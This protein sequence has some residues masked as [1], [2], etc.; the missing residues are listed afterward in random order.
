MRVLFT[1]FAEDVGLIPNSAFTKLLSDLEDTPQKFAPMA[2]AV[3]QNM[4]KGGFSPV[5]RE[6]LLRFNGGLFADTQALPLTSNQ[7]GLL[8]EAAKSDWSD[9]EPA[10]F[11][12][13]LERALHPDERHKLGAHYTPRAYVERLVLPTVIEPLRE[14][15]EAAKNNAIKLAKKGGKNDLKK[16]VAIVGDFLKHL[17]TITV[18]DPACGSGNFL[19]VTLEHLKRLEGEV[20]DFLHSN[21]E[22]IQLPLEYTGLTVD[23]H[24]L[25]GIE[26]NP[27]AAAITDLVLW[28]GY[29]QWHFRTKGHT[30]PQEPVLKKF[31]NIECRDAVLAYDS[32]ELARD[33]QGKPL[34]RWDGKTYKKHPIT[35]EDVPDEN[36]RVSI[37][38]YIN[39]RKAEWPKAEFVV[40]NPPFIGQQRM[41]NSLGD[42]YVDA[43]RTAHGDVPDTA[44][45]V[46]YWWNHATELVRL[47]RIRQSGLI[48]TNS[49]TQP[50]NRQ[51][52]ESHMRAKPPVALVFAV[53][54]HP[55]VESADG[56]AVRIAMTVA[57]VDTPISCLSTVAR[58]ESNEDGSVTVEMRET[59]GQ[60]NANLT[61]GADLSLTCALVANHGLAIKG[62]ELGSQGFLVDREGAERWIAEE[63]RYAEVLKPYMNGSDLVDG[64]YTRCVIDFFG[65]SEEQARH[66]RTVYQYVMDRV[67][68][69]R[70]VN[71]EER[72]AKTWW[73]FRRA[74]TE[75]RR[76]T[77][78]LEK[79]IATTRTAKHRVFQFLPSS[80]CSESKIV[81]IASQDPF[82]LGVLS[83]R[84]HLLWSVRIGGFLEDR[85]TYNH[86]DC[87]G[88]FPFPDCTEKQKKKIRDIAEELDAH[89]KRQQ[90]KY[91]DL[92]LTDMYNVLE[93]LRAIDAGKLSVADISPKDKKI[94]DHGLIAILKQLHDDLDAAVFDAYGWP[95]ALTDEQLLE[96]LVSLN[97]QRAAEE[98]RGKIRYLRPDFQCP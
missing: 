36:A 15:W 71:R 57:G 41:R 25:R 6:D 5:L 26:I 63:P 53:P 74:G 92:T 62:F 7:L 32:K 35:G 84:P 68:A 52:V 59:I 48:T 23:P 29:L 34:T 67:K 88:K 50:L 97:H 70:S 12:T 77:A 24:Q 83:S 91:P 1:L 64:R 33:E 73:L 17:C 86:D 81:V 11:G 49:I 10:I 4:D 98:K 94:H 79:Y 18:L 9:V 40:G 2:M 8:I 16:A 87:F 37:Y 54:D 39:P 46:M 55:W 93:K 58:E 96:K 28:I 56:A 21:F 31:N 22:N 47:K 85:P 75:L 60:I 82:H 78:D 72:T 61:T 90:A 66:Y 27:R 30:M 44:D 51:I 43:L 65:R 38:N 45:F 14:E 19:Y 20:H 13:L 89:R 95:A 42:G 69:E 80:V 3:W 76:A